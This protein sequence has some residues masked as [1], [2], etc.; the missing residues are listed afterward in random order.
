MVVSFM[1]RQGMSP[2]R[3]SQWIEADMSCARAGYMV[4]SFMVRQGMSVQRALRVFAEHRP[5]G[6]YKED[7]VRELYRYYHEPL[8]A[9]VLQPLLWLPLG[10]Q[11]ATWLVANLASIAVEDTTWP[12]MF[13]NL[14]FW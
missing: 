12:R 14:T 3:I 1:V 7:Y 8:C 13:G 6:I 10:R 2:E 5:P 9:R 11:K 4:V